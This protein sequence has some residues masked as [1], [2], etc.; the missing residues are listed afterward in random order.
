MNFEDEVICDHLVTAKT[1]EMWA[2]EMDMAKKLLEICKKHN[3]KIWASYGTL[4]GAVRH[5][6]FIPWD[7]DMDF[8]MLRED[9]NKL[10][11]IGAREFKEPYFFQSMYTD[12][13]FGG[14]I[15]IRNS[16]TAFIQK[17]HRNSKTENSGIAIDVF[18]IDALPDDVFSFEKKYKRNMLLRRMVNNYMVFRPVGSTLKTKVSSAL[19]EIF[20]KCFNVKAV[21]KYITKQLM[22]N[23]FKPNTKAACLEFYSTMSRPLSRVPIFNTDWF[24]ETVMLPFQ[25]MQVP[26]PIG[27][28]SLL[29]ALYGDYMKP[30]KGASFHDGD[31]L[32]VDTEHSYRDVLRSLNLE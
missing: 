21:D 17:S 15:K 24:A 3:L 9:F 12:H 7:D 23:P 1:K 14:M 6:G 29:K 25:E 31:V 28:D 19:I 20:F 11:V 2:V 13:S 32:C 22:K 16:K 4:L 26:A 5:K 27:Y 18:V 8:V 10:M 30:V